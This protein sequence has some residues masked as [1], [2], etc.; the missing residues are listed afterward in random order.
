MTKFKKNIRRLIFFVAAFCAIHSNALAASYPDSVGAVLSLGIS[1]AIGGMAITQNNRYL[2]VAYG[3]NLKMIDL[4]TFALAEEQ[5]PEL[6]EEAGTL[7]VIKDLAYSAVNNELYAVQDDGD[8]LIYNVSK[9]TLQPSVIRILSSTTLF[10][11]AI[12]DT[13]TEPVLYIGDNTNKAVYVWKR[14]A[15]GIIN[16]IS[17]TQ[18]LSSVTNWTMND[19]LYVNDVAE[20]FMSVGAGYLVWTN[21]NGTGGATRVALPY[22]YT[23]NMQAMAALPNG[24]KIYAIDSSDNNSIEI[25]STAT[26]TRQ[27]P[28]SI[29]TTDNTELIGIATFTGSDGFVYGYCSGLD[30]VSVWDTTN[31]TMIDQATGSSCIDISPSD[32]C[33]PIQ[34]S[35][36]GPLITS[37]DGY[38]YMSSAGGE[39]VL[40]TEN[41]VIDIV[42][43]KYFDDDEEETD[44]LH[45]GGT[46]QITWTS[47]QNGS[48]RTY[49]NG[50]ID[51]SGSALTDING[52]TG[53]SVVA[54]ETNVTT[55]AYDTNQ[56]I[57]EEGD[58]NLFFFV[59]NSAKLIGR[60][61]AVAFVDTPPPAVV[62]TGASFGNTRAY[63][64]FN[65]LT[66]NDMSHYNIYADT[67]PDAVKTK[68]ATSATK[69][70]PSSGA[71]VTA[72]ISGL[73][74]GTLYYL[75]IEG[76]DEGEN[77]GPRTYLLPDGSP[78]SATPQITVGPAG[79][80][81]EK[82]GCSLT[83]EGEFDPEQAACVLLLL[84]F[85]VIFNFIKRF[86]ATFFVV[87]VMS[88]F[89]MFPKPAQ[90]GGTEN[91]PQWWST[92]FKV[93]FW[94]PQDKVTKK[95]FNKCCNLVYM[96]N[97]GFLYDGKYGIEGGVGF[98]YEN[99]WAL[100]SATGERSGDR[101]NFIMVPMETTGVWRMDYAENQ[102]V[103]PYIKGGID[104]VYY[105]ESVK[106][107]VTQGLKTGLHAAGGMQFSLDFFDSDASLENDYG[108]NDIYFVIEARYNWINSFGKKGLDLSSTI[109]SAGFLMEF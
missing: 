92:E 5:P 22:G 60:I 54:G 33:Q 32:T 38:I 29:R 3:Q 96:V 30:G 44:A 94:M 66:P 95:F 17:L 86:P 50:S 45:Q 79:F 58:N 28:I 19:L 25:V 63:I 102:I 91:N 70:Q 6:T 8:L 37:G 14:S 71:H 72:E 74:N 9:I 73:T 51:E 13:G 99:G 64:T 81:G 97:G 15:G 61:A 18:V 105:R 107:S 103:V 55:F 87:L 36:Y 21:E 41:P 78:I 82:G 93:G 11:L 20:M 26:N 42:S 35:Y 80:S 62:V 46:V 98:M 104:Y 47:D 43:V 31:D 76:V 4:G 39:L 89:L 88:L 90:A 101:F 59:E 23:V 27:T 75:A 24:T 57:L 53:G 108:I 69:A 12:D 34:T 2:F 100:G 56:S 65:R 83:I 77:I 10:P 40:L 1:Q 67:D 49:A 84:I 106:G 68:S 52:A 16:T 109:Y 7:G 85:P 48:Y